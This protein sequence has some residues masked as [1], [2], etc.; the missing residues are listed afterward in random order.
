MPPACENPFMESDWTLD[1]EEVLAMPT[2]ELALAV[3]GDF[4]RGGGWN[5]YNW[6][7][8]AKDFYGHRID[9]E[10]AHSEAWG[11][12]ISRGLVARDFRKGHGDAVFV[13][14]AGERAIQEGLAEAR[15]VERL[16]ADLHP[17]IESRVRKTFLVGDYD[18]AVFKAFKQV[19]IRVRK[20]IDAPDGLVGTALMQ[21]AFKLDA[22]RL[23]TPAERSEQVARMEL[24]KGAFGFLRNPAGH[25]EVRYEDPTVASES[26]LLADLL[27][28]VLDRIEEE[29]AP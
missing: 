7:L 18:T 28:R 17:E 4:A 3:L 13:T 23:C 26:V 5:S 16:Q 24:F 20:M 22:G 9:V 19:E 6:I 2:D 21:E 25:R 1:A 29:L 10:Q 15:A 12:L 8:S 27:M 11:W 14:R